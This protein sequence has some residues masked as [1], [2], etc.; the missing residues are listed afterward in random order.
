MSKD[1]P[2]LRIIS[3]DLWTAA[4]SRQQQTRHAMKTRAPSA[5]AN[6]PQYLFSGLTKCGMC[7]AGFI[8]SGRIAS[9]ASAPATRGS[10][11]TT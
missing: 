10:A 8:M 5:V 3:D 4:K 7:G 9:D 1:V 6:R 11:T 2:H